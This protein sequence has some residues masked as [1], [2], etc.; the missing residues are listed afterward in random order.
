MEGYRE[1]RALDYYSN[2]QQR[3]Q[4][5]LDGFIGG[6]M[7]QVGIPGEGWRVGRKVGAVCLLFAMVFG[8]VGT[9]MPLEYGMTVNWITRQV[10][11]GHV[12]RGGRHLIGPWNRFISFPSTLVTVRFVEGRG[13][14]PLA[15]RTKDALPLTLQLSFQYRLQP[16]KLGELYR[17]ANLQYEPLFVRS[18]RDVLLKAAAEYEAIEYWENR[19]QIGVEMRELLNKRLTGSYATCGGL[20]L[21]MIELPDEYELS[22]VQ[23]QV[24]EQEVKT[25]QNEQKASQIEYETRVLRASFSRNVTVTRSGA[26]ALFNQETQIAAAKAEQRMVE[27]EAEAMGQVKLSL[28]LDSEQLVAYQQFAAYST[29]GN[30]SFIYGLGNTMLTVGAPR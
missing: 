6:V 22:I 8:S 5:E 12:Y 13:N 27:I 28:G 4:F 25:K 18:A 16:D 29:L 14:G 19:E 24:Q 9:L 2:R 21:L 11:S 1:A 15:T 20:Q 10:N 7:Q 3:D 23:T 30:A 26:D 17:L